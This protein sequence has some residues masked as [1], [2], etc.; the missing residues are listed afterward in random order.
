[1]TANRPKKFLSPTFLIVII[2]LL[3]FTASGF[4]QSLLDKKDMMF[5]QVFAGPSG[6]TSYMSVISA[7]NRGMLP[8][9]GNLFFETGASNIWNPL[10]NGSQVN[11]GAVNVTILPDETKVFTVTTNTFTVGYAYFFSSDYSLDNYVEG[12]L[13]YFAFNGSTLMDA[14]GVPESKE[15]MISSLPFD[16]YADVGLSLVN[17][18]TAAAEVDVLLFDPDGGLPVANCTFTLQPGEHYAKYLTELPWFVDPVGFGPIGKVEISSDIPISGI[19][20]LI[21]PGS[22]AG[23]QISTLPLGGTPLTY[24]ATFTANSAVYEGELALWIDGFRVKGYLQITDDGTGP[25]DNSNVRPILVNGQLIGDELDL[26][27]FTGPANTWPDVERFGAV[28]YIYVFGFTPTSNLMDNSG[29]RWTAYHVWDTA[30]DL[31]EGGVALDNTL[32]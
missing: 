19:A 5:T 13:S 23:A 8:Y 15:F 17:P 27:C 32:F 11:G 16:M 9:T 10:V 7:T 26:T 31:V 28:L 1:M 14:V 2:L 20:M 12:N 18:A 22:S 25:V 3:A 21:T 24:L 30:Q 6:G 4:S 29:N